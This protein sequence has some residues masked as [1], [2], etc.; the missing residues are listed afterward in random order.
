MFDICFYKI[1]FIITVDQFRC[2]FVTSLCNI[3]IY[4][5]IYIYILIMVRQLFTLSS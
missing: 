4:I 1:G 3:Y 2:R 5:Y